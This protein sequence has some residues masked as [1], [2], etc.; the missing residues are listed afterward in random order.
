MV[1]TK[2]QNDYTS[3]TIITLMYSVFN[4]EELDI[5]RNLPEVRNTQ[6]TSRTYFQASVPDSIKQKLQNIK[7][8]LLL[9]QKENYH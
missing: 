8:N 9:P 1:K 2:E 3:I 4:Q 7:R 5:L 6:G